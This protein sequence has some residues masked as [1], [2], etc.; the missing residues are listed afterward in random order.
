MRPVY[1]QQKTAACQ[2]VQR[3]VQWQAT[4][5]GLV[6]YG[7]AQQ[8]QVQKCMARALFDQDSRQRHVCFAVFRKAVV[9]VLHGKH[10]RLAES[11]PESLLQSGC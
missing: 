7:P 4:W 11:M 9:I 8:N 5:L 2:S 10:E 1:N 6:K 3:K